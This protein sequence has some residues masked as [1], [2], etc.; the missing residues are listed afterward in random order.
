[1]GLNKRLLNIQGA[2]D[3]SGLTDPFDD[4]SGLYFHTF[5]NT[6]Q[7]AN[8]GFDLTPYAGTTNLTTFGGKS[9][10]YFDGNDAIG[11]LLRYTYQRSMF[12]NNNNFSIS[13]F[14]QQ[15][16]TNYGGIFDFRRQN[17]GDPGYNV[18]IK[19]NGV[20]EYYFAIKQSNGTVVSIQKQA[21]FGWKHLVFTGSNSNIRIYINGV[22]ESITN[23]DGT[24][25]TETTTENYIG[26]DDQSN[27][28]GQFY[29]SKLRLFNKELDSTKVSELYAI[30][31]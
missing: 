19:Y 3:P 29:L 13:C 16:T 9:C 15:S 24:F 30:D 26:F 8:G 12:S 31:S 14:I 1:M 21:G 25:R 23:W 5:D 17:T 10:A 22:Q 18:R 7:E 11:A 20:R 27:S 6:F 4:G 28:Y 2:Q